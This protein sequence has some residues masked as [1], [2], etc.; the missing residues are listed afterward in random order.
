M[1][2][3]VYRMNPKNYI[4]SQRL[5]YLG[6]GGTVGYIISLN[7]SP[8]DFYLLAGFFVLVIGFSEWYRRKK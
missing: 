5:A 1:T 6:M 2:G 7:E 3:W 8:I 4:L